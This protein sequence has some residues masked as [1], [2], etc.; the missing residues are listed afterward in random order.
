MSGMTLG[1]E[2]IKGL[3]GTLTPLKPKLCDISDGKGSDED[4]DKLGVIE[5]RMAKK[6]GGEM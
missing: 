4:S 3:D 6:S 1:V 2:Y 5:L